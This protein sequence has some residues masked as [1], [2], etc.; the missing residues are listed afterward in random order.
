LRTGLKSYRIFPMKCFRRTKPM[1]REGNHEQ[2]TSEDDSP[3]A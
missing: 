3:R 1:K 2:S